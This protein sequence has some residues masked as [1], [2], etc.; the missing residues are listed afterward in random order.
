MLARQDRLL[1]R[2]GG[3]RGGARNHRSRLTGSQRRQRHPPDGSEGCCSISWKS[4]LSTRRSVAIYM[5]RCLVECRLSP[6][7]YTTLQPSCNEVFLLTGSWGSPSPEKHD[8]PNELQSSLRQLKP[9]SPRSHLTNRQTNGKI[10]SGVSSAETP[11]EEV[12]TPSRTRLLFLL[13][14]QPR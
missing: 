5:I 7:L 3:S 10:D 8:D 1:V 11:R 2:R 4:F 14:M 13:P 6:C 12:R 9:Q